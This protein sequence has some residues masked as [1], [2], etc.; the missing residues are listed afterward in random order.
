MDSTLYVAMC[1]I[2]NFSS[3]HIHY[4]TVL[5]STA[6]LLRVLSLEFLEMLSMFYVLYDGV[7][8][9]LI[10]VCSDSCLNEMWAVDP[11]EVLVLDSCSL[12]S[13]SGLFFQGVSVCSTGLSVC[14]YVVF[15]LWFSKGRL[16]W[17]RQFNIV[18]IKFSFKVLRRDWQEVLHI[19]YG[20]NMIYELMVLS[21]G[22]IILT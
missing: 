16:C 2:I 20:C 8:I 6:A 15:I 11:E 9:G 12:C 22:W 5:V 3:H 7:V 17:Q 18:Q 13:P 21:R 19:Y 10:L 4:C 1:F 14:V